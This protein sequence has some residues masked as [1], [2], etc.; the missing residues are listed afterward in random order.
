LD[1]YDEVSGGRLRREWFSRSADR[2]IG[3]NRADD[4]CWPPRRSVPQ[5]AAC[6]LRFQHDQPRRQV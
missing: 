5:F 3:R 1:G 2:P 6:P 4:L